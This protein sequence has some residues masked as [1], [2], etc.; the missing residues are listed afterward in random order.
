M[1]TMNVVDGDG[2]PVA[3]EKPLAPGRAAEASSR[4]VV[5][6]TEDKAAVDALATKQDTGN[7]SLASILTKL[8][9]PATQTTLAAVLDKLSSDP[10]TE[11]TLGAANTSLA[12]ILTAVS[13][14]T[15][16][17]VDKSGQ[18]TSGGASQALAAANAN[19]LGLA[20]QNLSSGDLWVNPNGVDATP[21]SPS[22]WL[23]P[24]TY[25]EI[26]AS[27]VSKTAITIYGATTGQKWSAWEW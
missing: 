4:P 14:P 18:V 19:R 23:P 25:F 3:V 6:S 27:G 9:D 16:T 2:N 5:L 17:Y 8:A 24:G 7:T 20:I 12:S 1:A 11:T 26:P 10:A 21:T 22:I 13:K 15:I